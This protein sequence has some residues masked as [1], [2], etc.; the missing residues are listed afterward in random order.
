M[1]DI[2]KANINKDKLDDPTGRKAQINKKFTKK[3]DKILEYLERNNISFPN[4]EDNPRA[5]LKQLRNESEI[6]EKNN[7]LDRIEG[8]LADIYKDPSNN[9]K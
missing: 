2:D 1:N 8:I 4:T 3:I 5:L 9:L 6:G 7:I